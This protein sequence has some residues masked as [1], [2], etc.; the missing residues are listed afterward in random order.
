MMSDVIDMI[1]QD[2]RELERLF[3]QLKTQ[4]EIRRATVPVMITLLTAH[5][6]AEEAVVYPAAADAG[7]ASDV[8]H[9]QKEHLTADQ[10]AAELA[11][12]DPNSGDF[13]TKLQELVD[14]VQHH[15]EEE[16]QTVL[17]GLRGRLDPQRLDELGT[18]FLDS[19]SQHLGQEP[20]DITKDEVQQQARNAGVDLPSDATKDEVQEALATNAES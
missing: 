20:D 7:G 16:E 17:P 19:R 13:A 9:S 5:S 2:H 4:P 14:A 10:L 8:E 1:T 12:A 18:A 11:A 3:E 6:R 15:V